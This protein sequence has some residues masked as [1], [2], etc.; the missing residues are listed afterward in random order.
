MSNPDPED[1]RSE[2]RRP[3]PCPKNG[4]PANG[5]SPT[6]FFSY[7]PRL[8]RS[9]ID[10]R[11]SPSNIRLQAGRGEQ[12]LPRSDRYAPD[13]RRRGIRAGRQQPAAQLPAGFAE[14]AKSATTSGKADRYPISSGTV[15]RHISPT[16]WIHTPGSSLM[17]ASSLLALLFV[18]LEILG[19]GTPAQE[20]ST[21]ESPG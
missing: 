11:T 20:A 17:K 9:M 1:R 21:A 8:R 4:L 14:E 5:R 3:T 12:Q 13:R 7:V 10:P 18:A 19:C 16:A 15:T 6:S 2:H